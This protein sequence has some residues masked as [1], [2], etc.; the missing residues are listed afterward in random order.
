MNRTDLGYERRRL[1]EPT[2]AAPVYETTE[3]H[4]KQHVPEAARI[5]RYLGNARNEQRLLEAFNHIMK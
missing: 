2:L 4:F 5:R 3:D 1:A